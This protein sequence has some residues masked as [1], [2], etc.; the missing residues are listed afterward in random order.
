MP[1]IDDIY[2]ENNQNK[3]KCLELLERQRKEIIA[4]LQE[5]ILND[6]TFRLLNARILEYIR[7][8][9][10]NRRNRI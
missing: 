10:A 6:V 3:E 2:I 1:L 5:G 7:K 4:L 8:I 9:N